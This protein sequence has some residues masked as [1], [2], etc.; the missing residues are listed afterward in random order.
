VVPVQGS[1][2]LCRLLHRSSVFLASLLS[3]W[4]I[5]LGARLQLAAFCVCLE[6]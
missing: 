5:G 3:V 4:L 6:G 2:A 1:H